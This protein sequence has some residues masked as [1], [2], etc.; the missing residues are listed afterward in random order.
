MSDLQIARWHLPVCHRCKMKT[1]LLLSVI[2]QLL[3][4]K[5]HLTDFSVTGRPLGL[6]HLKTQYG[7]DLQVLDSGHYLFSCVSAS[8]I[9]FFNDAEIKFACDVAFML[10]SAEKPTVDELLELAQGARDE[11]NRV[12]DT[13]LE[14][15]ELGI[16]QIARLDI[17][18]TEAMLRKALEMPD[19]GHLKP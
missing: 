4:A 12:F 2:M 13:K 7:Y 9:V 3:E 15:R 14:E 8:D 1:S 11:M 18:E 5:S 10:G 6:F 16:M 19:E 17:A